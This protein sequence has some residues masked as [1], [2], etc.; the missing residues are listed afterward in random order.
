MISWNKALVLL[1]ILSIHGAYGY[2]PS[3]A[4]DQAHSIK[5]EHDQALKDFHFWLDRKVNAIP[6]ALMKGQRDEAK[7]HA[8]AASAL[9][10]NLEAELR[11]LKAEITALEHKLEQARVHEQVALNNSKE[12][13]Q[14]SN[15][16][17]VQQQIAVL[18]AKLLALQERFKQLPRHVRLLHPLSEWIK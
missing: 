6:R 8:L 10:Q 16:E 9:V 1:S 17:K 18:R 15:S 7:K 12:W 11:H 5:T 3:A 4:V 13:T 2:A 14:R